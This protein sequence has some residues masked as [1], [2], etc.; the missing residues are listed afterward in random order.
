MNWRVYGAHDG[1]P[2]TVFPIGDWREHDP[3]DPQ[4]WCRPRWDDGVLVHNA[5]DQREAYEEGRPMS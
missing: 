2:A 1:K 3:D 4:C 5:M